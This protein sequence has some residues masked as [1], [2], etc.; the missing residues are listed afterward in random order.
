MSKSNVPELRLDGF[1]GEWNREALG[2]LAAVSSAARVHRNDWRKSGIPFFRTSDVTAMASGKKNERVY[3]DPAL[4]QELTARS[5]KLAAGD[6]LIVGGGSIGTPY[7]VPD[8]SPLYSK[9]A[10][11]LWVKPQPA[12]D[13][14]FFTSFLATSVFTSYLKS[15]SHIGTISHYTIE[16][17]KVTPVPLPPTVEEQQAIGG[18]FTNL[19]TAINSHKKKLDLLKQTKTSLLQRM[20]PQD[21]ATVPELRLEGFEGEWGAVS[22]KTLSDERYVTLGRG[23][24]ISQVDIGNHLG[25]YPI[26]SS[27]AKGDGV[28]GYYGRYMFADERIT[29]SIDGGGRFFYRPAHRYSVTNVCGWL[30]VNTLDIDT[31]F[32]YL[33]L[34]LQWLQQSF[35]YMLKAHPSNIVE[36]YKPWLPPTVE[37]QRAIG[38]VFAKLDTLISTEAQYID[39]LT[40]TKTALLQKMF[41]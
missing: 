2:N 4:Y 10:D 41:V 13:S 37:E 19:D 27:S 30:K 14:Y 32:L 40:Q 26:Y 15:I 3:I 7:I 18:I 21:G 5:G 9:D 22:L 6:I 35:D 16:Q 39:K 38:A 12:L 17:A 36:I 8:N 31:R 29:W 28:F 34:Y 25:R 1:E 24:V 11:L 20:F 23:E 33:S